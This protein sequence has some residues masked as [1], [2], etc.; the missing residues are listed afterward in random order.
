MSGLFG[1]NPTDTI[2]GIV[3]H[4]FPQPMTPGEAQ[5]DAYAEQIINNA[6]K[7]GLEPS[8]AYPHSEAAYFIVAWAV[9]HADNGPAAERLIREGIA[10][11]LPTAMRPTKQPDYVKEPYQFVDW[12]ITNRSDPAVLAAGLM[13]EVEASRQHPTGDELRSRHAIE[14]LVHVALTARAA[15]EAAKN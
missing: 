1:E 7:R 2:P 3:R 4:F 10:R 9:Q 5:L 11:R 6:L 13:R 14:I 12:L 8:E 15:K